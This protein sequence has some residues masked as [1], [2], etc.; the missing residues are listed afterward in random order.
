M[1]CNEEH[2]LKEHLYTFTTP[3]KEREEINLMTKETMV[4]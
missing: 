1:G 3:T 2:Q 4:R